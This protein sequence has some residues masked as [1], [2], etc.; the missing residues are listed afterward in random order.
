M[1]CIYH[2]LTAPICEAAT[3]Y[4]TLRTSASEVSIEEVVVAVVEG[5]DDAGLRS[6][7]ESRD[8]ILRIES[9]EGS[10][11]DEV[12]NVQNGVGRFSQVH[13]T[14]VGLM[15]LSVHPYVATIDATLLTGA[16]AEIRWLAGPAQTFEI[17]QPTVQGN[18]VISTDEELE[19]TVTTYDIHGNPSDSDYRTCEVIIDVASVSEAA[20]S[21]SPTECSRAVLITR[22]IGTTAISSTAVQ[23][24]RLRIECTGRLDLKLGG[25]DYL[26]VSVVA[27]AAKMILMEGSEF[28]AVAGSPVSIQLRSVDAHG[29]LATSFSGFATLKL[30]ESSACQ[31]SRDRLPPEPQPSFTAGRATAQFS[32]LFAETCTAYLSS[33]NLLAVSVAR[34]TAKLTWSPALPVSYRISFELSDE[35]ASVDNLANVT[36]E[37]LDNYG[38]VAINQIGSFTGR[39]SLAP[40]SAASAV[41]DNSIFFSAGYSYVQV[42][43]N[44]PE[45][46]TVGITTMPSGG[47]VAVG[48][49]HQIEFLPGRVVE[50]VFNA[51]RNTVVGSAMALSIVARDQYGNPATSL[52]TSSVWLAVA[53]GTAV[54]LDPAGGMLTLTN[55]VAT[56]TATSKVAQTVTFGLSDSPGGSSLTGGWSFVARIVGGASRGFTLVNG[57]GEA[58]L[59][60]TVAEMVQAGVEDDNGRGV[61]ID[62]L[63]TVTFVPGRAAQLTVSLNATEASIDEAV[64]ASVS[65][66]D[67]YGNLVVDYD[68][69]GT[70]AW[71]VL[72]TGS[73][74][75]QLAVF[76][77]GRATTILTA[78]RLLSPPSEAVSVSLLSSG[79]SLGLS[80][81]D[82]TLVWTVGSARL[83]RLSGGRAATVGTDATIT[84][85]IADSHGN[86]LTALDQSYTVCLALPAAAILPRDRCITMASPSAAFAFSSLKAG[87]IV[88]SL[89]SVNPDTLVLESPKDVL[90]L[91]VTAAQYAADNNA[92]GCTAALTVDERTSTVDDSITATVTARDP[93]G[94]VVTDF[95]GHVEIE[96]RRGDDIVLTPS[97]IV[98]VNGGVGVVSVSTEVPQTDV[99]L[100][101]VDSS[102]PQLLIDDSAS[103]KI[104]FTAGEASKYQLSTGND[105]LTV[106]STAAVVVTVR[107]YDKFGN[108]PPAPFSSGKNRVQVYVVSGHILPSVFTAELSAQ[109]DAEAEFIATKA[110]VVSLGLRN[111]TADQPVAL[112]SMLTLTFLPGPVS[113]W[114]ID[115]PTVELAGRAIDCLITARDSFGNAVSSLPDPQFI[116]VLIRTA[117]TKS[118]SKVE[119][120]EQTLLSGGQAVLEVF[121]PEHATIMMKAIHNSTGTESETFIATFRSDITPPRI[122]FVRG[123]ISTTS[124]G[125]NYALSE[126]GFVL[127]AALDQEAY[128]VFERTA[129]EVKWRQILDTPG[130]GADVTG[131][132]E[133]SGS[134]RISGLVPDTAHTV[135]CYAGDDQ[136]PP[137]MSTK[138]DIVDN[139]FTVKTLPQANT[140]STGLNDGSDSDSDTGDDTGVE[141]LAKATEMQQSIMNQLMNTVQ[142]IQSQCDEALDVVKERTTALQD[143]LALAIANGGETEVQNRLRKNAS[144]IYED[145]D[146]VLHNMGVLDFGRTQD[147]EVVDRSTASMTGDRNEEQLELVKGAEGILNDIYE[148]HIRLADLDGTDVEAE[149][150]LLKHLKEL[151]RKLSTYSGVINEEEL[152]RLHDIRQQQIKKLEDARRVG[153][154]MKSIQQ[155]RH[156]LLAKQASEVSDLLGSHEKEVRGAEGEALR[157]LR[158]QEGELRMKRDR[159]RAEIVE[160]F[161]RKIESTSDELEKQRLIRSG[162][163]AMT[164]LDT[165]TTAERR[166]LQERLKQKAEERAVARKAKHAD[167]LRDL[168]AKHKAEVDALNEQ[169][170]NLKRQLKDGR[171]AIMIKINDIV[172]DD[173]VNAVSSREV[174][175]ALQREREERLYVL[176]ERHERKLKVV[177]GDEEDIEALVRDYESTVVRAENEMEVEKLEQLRL[178]RERLRDR[179]AKRQAIFK[180][181]SEA[182]DELRDAEHELAGAEATIL[183]KQAFELLATASERAELEFETVLAGEMENT[184][185]VA[186]LEHAT[187]LQVA[188]VLMGGGPDAEQVSGKYLRQLE[189]VQARV[190]AELGRHNA[191]QLAV[192]TRLNGKELDNLRVAHQREREK[193][194][195]NHRQRKEVASRKLAVVDEE[196]C[197]ELQASS[198]ASM[199][200][201]M[202]MLMQQE[203][204]PAPQCFCQAVLER[205]DELAREQQIRRNYAHLRRA[206]DVSLGER[207][208]SE[209]A[210]RAE[211]QRLRNELSVLDEEERFMASETIDGVVQTQGTSIKDH[212]ET[213]TGSGRGLRFIDASVSEAER[214][215]LLQ[216]H[217]LRRAEIEGQI[218][219]HQEAQKLALQQKFAARRRRIEAKREQIVLDKVRRSRMNVY[220]HRAIGALGAQRQLGKSHAEEME[221]MANRHREREDEIT[222]KLEEEARKDREALEDR[223]KTQMEELEGRLRRALRKAGNPRDSV[224]V[225]PEEMIAVREEHQEAIAAAAEELEDEKKVQELIM[226]KKIAEREARM[227]KSK[228]KVKKKHRQEQVL[229]ELSYE[230]GKLQ[231]VSGS[232][233]K[234]NVAQLVSSLNKVNALMRML[235]TDSDASVSQTARRFTAVGPAIALESQTSIRPEPPAAPPFVEPPETPVN[236]LAIQLSQSGSLKVEHADSP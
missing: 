2:G 8:L 199:T 81:Q 38:N 164:E 133:L 187:N 163:E 95:S 173:L 91:P 69:D 209:A 168:L 188:G 151:E 128:E 93:Y 5:F 157:Q 189:E 74:S 82:A 33:A 230:Q 141:V 131:G 213:G 34:E 16:T 220:L 19:F 56:A 35:A 224:R 228:D 166:E 236:S 134:L 155:A 112:R 104:D 207:S 124:V 122:T 180:K 68:A 149:Q 23:T 185:V 215:R 26:D 71:K 143:E 63:V 24:L 61:E 94:N 10:L 177:R 179:R 36:F 206:A 1:S 203:I 46:V 44:V 160:K 27:G 152:A 195:T 158:E 60:H 184:S 49:S 30:Q 66:S 43:H 167:E 178:N 130:K 84:V 20:V 92:I 186:S 115:G 222:Q 126:P 229:A 101:L 28:T 212:E 233:G 89:E 41:P 77:G 218:T 87:L 162:M 117:L 40:P 45:V 31:L 139:E 62:P 96:V 75:D 48:G 200:A 232:G 6:L 58:R 14:Q 79:S 106:S 80:V 105:R 15:K 201:R 120:T 59:E 119:R 57:E 7:T 55:G 132:N 190:V 182:E 223:Y 70:V 219:D 210:R 150:I 32:N 37:L 86:L 4:F 216:E 83:I 88:V 107:A 53:T 111:A 118:G 114:R 147:L 194:S 123:E 98:K 17:S 196:I 54:Q 138:D 191:G 109:G 65:C 156:E 90:F 76:A 221:E 108:T 3:A 51:T 193:I 172:G 235:N 227:K 169:I 110:G 192:V 170:N 99:E 145:L 197:E 231:K 211:E 73:P 116:T 136:S 135:L 161:R 113:S 97:N 85:E 217:E 234:A 52:S 214:Q 42:S 176:K 165:N 204:W 64:L 72:G 18:I 140:T 102:D 144:R 12:V 175:E 174:E 39:L 47:L 183:E 129:D 25:I 171:V 121:A 78:D 225:A 50:V 146:E 154:E 103:V 198:H 208:E 22:G 205:S 21:C 202:D 226:Q 9:P 181:R 125:V 67:R 127:C 11:R 29:N 13:S 148:L 153:E 137:N 142:G 100:R 159:Q